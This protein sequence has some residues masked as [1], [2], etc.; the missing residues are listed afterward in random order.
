M[1]SPESAAFE[2]VEY[3][4]ADFRV[5]REQRFRCTREL[6]YKRASQIV[7]LYLPWFLI[8]RH[9]EFVNWAAFVHLSRSRVT[10]Q[11]SV[12]Q[13]SQEQ[14]GVWFDDMDEF[15]NEL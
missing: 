3:L 9:S 6:W 13:L 2:C 5:I 10:K 1:F 12:S 11:D 14:I 15:F 4:L 8:S 7:D